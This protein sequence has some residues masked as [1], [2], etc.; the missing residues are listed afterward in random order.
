MGADIL[1]SAAAALA[2]GGEL[3]Y[4]TCTFAPEEDEGQVAAFL[5]RHPEFTLADVLGLTLADLMHC[6][7]SRQKDDTPPVPLEDFFT[8]LRRQHTV[9]WH[10]VRTA[11]LALS[12][13]LALWGIFA[14]PGRL[15]VHWRTL[16]DG[17]LQADG[18]MSSLVYFSI[19]CRI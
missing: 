13:A 9:D 12:I 16:S 4:S 10:S 19:V 2:P 7:D 5:Q 1:D 14:C 15:A 6:H 11:L 3:V 8:M 17:L 18:W